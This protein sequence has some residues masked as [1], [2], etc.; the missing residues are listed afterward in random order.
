MNHS[1]WDYSYSWS[2]DDEKESEGELDPLE[3]A[4][5]LCP[6]RF[7]PKEGD[8]LH[9]AFSGFNA[10]WMDNVHFYFFWNEKLY[11]FLKWEETYQ[12]RYKNLASETARILYRKIPDL[13]QGAELLYS[14]EKDSVQ[15][16]DAFFLLYYVDI[17]IN[18][19]QV[20][21]YVL[22]Y[23]LLVEQLVSGFDRMYH[24]LDAEKEN[25]SGKEA[26]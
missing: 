19:D 17:E 7:L 25:V 11:R 22:F 13:L 1:G 16:G 21:P 5:R 23:M 6:D 18:T 3:L 10:S 8:G 15:T 12:G 4:G 24:F 14:T 26:A 2:P 9:E 20:S